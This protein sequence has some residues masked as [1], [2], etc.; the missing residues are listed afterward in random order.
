MLPL[1]DTHTLS[2]YCVFSLKTWI[3]EVK[4][5]FPSCPVTTGMADQIC[6]SGQHD[7]LHHRIQITVSTSHYIHLQTRLHRRQLFVMIADN[8][9]LAL[10]YFFIMGPN[11]FLALSSNK[12]LYSATKDGI[13]YKIASTQYFTCLLFVLFSNR[14]I[15][16][17]LHF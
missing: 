16:E 6:G 15:R 4:S 5:N 10:C 12:C 3:R 1:S 17:H 14:H 11:S 13:R 2:L 8:S 9:L 7:F